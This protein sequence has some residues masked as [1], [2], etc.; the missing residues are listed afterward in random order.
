MP[1][2][3]SVSWGGSATLEQTGMLEALKSS[4]FQTIDRATAKT[5][6]E[7]QECFH[8]A[9]SADYYFMST[10]A[11]TTAGELVNVDKKREPGSRPGVRSQTCDDTGRDE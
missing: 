6:A 2:G 11:I 7:T 8:R 3:T 9:L 1:E 4:G 5:P 10:N